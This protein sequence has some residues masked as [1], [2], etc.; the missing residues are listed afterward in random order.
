MYR[1]DWIRIFKAPVAAL[2]IVALMV[3][4]S[5][6]AWFNLATSWDPYSNTSGIKI[7]VTSEDDGAVIRDSFVNIGGEI[8]ASLKENDKL[9]W[10]FVRK[11]KA[12]KGVRKG[13]YYASLYIPHDFSAKIATILADKQVKPEIDYSVN[14]KLNAKR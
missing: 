10:E 11:E 2:L 6:Y 1:N 8:V 4:P 9:G 13:E 5:L 3:L 12:K 14:E 7:A